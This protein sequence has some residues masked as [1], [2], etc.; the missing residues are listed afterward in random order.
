M[1]VTSEH[2][3]ELLMFV[4]IANMVCCGCVVYPGN[5]SPED[6]YVVINSSSG[7]SDSDCGAGKEE[8]TTDEDIDN[9]I[10][11]DSPFSDIASNSD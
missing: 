1:K 5:T 4:C 10:V 2:M 8:D 9:F 11:D 6:Q 3:T 7:T